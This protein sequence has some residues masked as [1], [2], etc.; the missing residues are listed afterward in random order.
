MFLEWG[1]QRGLY[2]RMLRSRILPSFTFQANMNKNIM[3]LYL[4]VYNK[5]EYNVSSALCVCSCTFTNDCLCSAR[6][7]R[8]LACV[9]P[10]VHSLLRICRERL[11]TMP[12]GARQRALR[13]FGV[14]VRR[15]AR[16]YR[17]AQADITAN[18]VAKDVVRVYRRLC[19]TVH[20]SKRFGDTFARNLF[21]S[22]V[23]IIYIRTPLQQESPTRPDSLMCGN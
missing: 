14:V 15:M 19:K 13:A 2:Y 18:S 3:C 22:G 21:G 12:T 11:R 1:K 8:L 23:S 4:Y 7:D 20:P 17:L 9:A 10:G 6:S 16:K 5:Y